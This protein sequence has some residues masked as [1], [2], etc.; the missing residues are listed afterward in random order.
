M[1]VDDSEHHF[2]VW[3]V[4]AYRYVDLHWTP[5]PLISISLYMELGSLGRTGLTY[6]QHV[7]ASKR[8]RSSSSASADVS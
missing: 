3:T 2:R 4:K 8:T 5:A 1:H 7:A 6:V